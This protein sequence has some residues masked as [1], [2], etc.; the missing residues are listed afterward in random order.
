MKTKQRKPPGRKIE[1]IQYPESN[2]ERDALLDALEIA[3]KALTLA[4]GAIPIKSAAFIPTSIDRDL[5][6]AAVEKANWNKPT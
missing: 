1:T 2:K 4:L 6:R 3:D 5:V